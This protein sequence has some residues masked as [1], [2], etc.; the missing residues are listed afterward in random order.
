[1]KFNQKIRGIQMIAR[2]QVAAVTGLMTG[3][4][5]MSAAVE[6]ATVAY[7]R[8]ENTAASETNSPLLDY[9]AGSTAG[10][11]TNVADVNIFDPVA[12][13]TVANT[14]SYDHGAG[15]ASTVAF[16][17]INAAVTGNS[18]F[19]VE[20]FVRLNSGGTFSFDNIIKNWTGSGNDAGW[21]FG[22]DAL[23]DAGGRLSFF[24]ALT[25]G[26][27]LTKVSPNVLPQDTWIHVAAVGTVTAVDR[28]SVQLFE[29]Y[30][31]AGTPQVFIG[32]VGGPLLDANAAAYS[33]GATNPFTGL[34]DELRISDL[35]LDSSQFL[36]ATAIPEPASIALLSMGL[37]LI[38]GRRRSIC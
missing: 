1:M 17:D 4:L 32:S 7:W 28:V 15:T 26:G 37:V 35:A 3:V 12:N 27:T 24:G 23:G 18:G 38:G 8:A 33:I 29:N 11:S 21:G 25:T 10:F 16:A 6:A 14:A 5:G 36:Q 30:V 20:A 13:T 2:W 22:L 34:I 19:T 31:A 9:T